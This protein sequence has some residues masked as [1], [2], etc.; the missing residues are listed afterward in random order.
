MRPATDMTSVAG[1]FCFQ[2]NEVTRDRSKSQMPLITK[3]LAEIIAEVGVAPS[4]VREILKRLRNFLLN[5]P[6]YQVRSNFLGRFYV[7]TESERYFWNGGELRVLPERQVV[8]MRV[9]SRKSTVVSSLSAS[10]TWQTRFRA[11]SLW[12][13]SQISEPVS[14]NAGGLVSPDRSTLVLGQPYT[15]RIIRL[16]SQSQPDRLAFEWKFDTLQLQLSPG[17]VEYQTRT[18]RH[19]FFRSGDHFIVDGGFAVDRSPSAD[20][21]FNIDMEFQLLSSPVSSDEEPVLGKELW[22][23]AY[24][25]KKAW[26][27]LQDIAEGA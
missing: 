3:P 18:W 4:E 12:P 14:F 2:L 22:G 20:A 9:K 6:G 26:D 19:P 27:T 8:A 23:R 17:N 5:N 11:Q 24:D 21:L 10:S 16:P 7:R 15:Q 13:E 25:T 1:F